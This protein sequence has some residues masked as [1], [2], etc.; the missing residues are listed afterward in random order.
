MSD[1]EEPL[2]SGRR[3]PRRNQTKQRIRRKPCRHSFDTLG[4]RPQ[5]FGRWACP[6]TRKNVRR[7][8]TPGMSDREQ[9]EGKAM[10]RVSLSLSC[11]V[12]AR[13]EPNWTSRRTERRS[14]DVGMEMEME[15]ESDRQEKCIDTAERIPFSSQMALCS[16]FA[17]HC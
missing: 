5:Y 11:H 17:F 2:S 3:N 7:P 13:C 8:R 16:S 4:N 14:T 9:I 1:I 15:N 10:S 12:A 6:P